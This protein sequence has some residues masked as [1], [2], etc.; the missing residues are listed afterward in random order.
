MGKIS[1]QNVNEGK[2]LLVRIGKLIAL[3]DC[4]I[5]D[6][7]LAQT[8]EG[9]RKREISDFEILMGADAPILDASLPDRHE[10]VFDL[11]EDRVVLREFRRQDTLFDAEG[12]EIPDEKEEI[13]IVME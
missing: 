7:F 11:Q 6:Q 12:I 9:S 2:N 1:Q 5:A 13:L 10:E 3:D 8:Q 4:R